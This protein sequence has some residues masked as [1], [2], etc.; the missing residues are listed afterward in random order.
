[1]STIDRKPTSRDGFAALACD[2]DGTLA[3]EGRVAPATLSALERVGAGG[4]GL[5]L[6][7]GR[8]LP[9]LRRVFP[10]L[11]CFDRVV[12]ENGALLAR[13][14]TGDE[15]VLG[16]PAEPALLEALRAC[17]V[18]PLSAGRSIVAT[19]EPYQAAAREVIRSLGLKR[20]I[21][22]NKGAVMLLPSGVDKA[23]GLEHA[24][25]DL[26]IPPFRTIGV[27]DAEN[28]L[29]FLH[30]CG[31]AVAVGNALPEVCEQVDFVTEGEN[32]AGVVELIERLLGDALPERRPARA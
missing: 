1:M 28:D 16:D 24:L 15:R 22:L 31:Y 7:T 27:G 13:P 26:A 9:D 2:Y 29:T 12:A 25:Q 23:F 11:G 3:H 17:G 14:A 18:T 8:E 20:Q 19:R 32:G 30:H 6:V 10:E 4:W 5:V 21:V